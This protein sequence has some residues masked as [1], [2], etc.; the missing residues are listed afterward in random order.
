MTPLELD[1]PFW[2]FSLT[3]YAAPGVAP[4][5]LAL[6]DQL[7]LDVNV[8]L[9][10]AWLGLRGTSIK[11]GDLARIADVIAPWSSDVVKPLRQV[12]QHLKPLSDSDAAVQNLRK[13]IADAELFSEQIEQA[14]LY[15][16][17]GSLG[18]AISTPGAATAQANV[19]VI[20]SAAGSTD[21]S[22]PLTELWAACAAYALSS[23]QSPPAR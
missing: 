2:R 21:A 17:A 18:V 13:R 14:Q 5:C 12:R 4:E 9:F 3:V 19:A 22:F 11:Q 8:I 10:A 7:G 6:Q 16:I 1:N 20:L 15:A 23:P